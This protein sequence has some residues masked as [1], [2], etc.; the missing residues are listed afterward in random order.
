MPL[1]KTQ[2]LLHGL[3][4]GSVPPSLSANYVDLARS[5]GD[6]A[7]YVALPRVGHME[8]ISGRGAIFAALA[9]RLDAVFGR[10]Q[11]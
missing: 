6:P 7:E 11:A 9:A 8:M 3:A 2:I 4:D 10:P 5:Q 1:G